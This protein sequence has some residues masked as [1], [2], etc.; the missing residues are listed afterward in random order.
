M[1]MLPAIT[2]TA[3]AYSTGDTYPQEYKNLDYYW[4]FN[5][6]P[7][8]GT[9]DDWN[10]CIRQCTS[11][12]AWC[13]NDRNGIP[14]TNQYKGLK[15]WG[16]GGQWGDSA[17]KAGMTVDMNPSV[18]SVAYWDHGTWGHVAWVSAVNGSTVTIEEYNYWWSDGPDQ[19]GVPGIWNWDTLPVRR[20][21]WSDPP[22]G[23]IHFPM[24][25]SVTPS[26]PTAPVQN[27]GSDFYAYI[28]NPNSGLFLEN[29]NSNVQ[30]ATPNGY[31]PRQIW[32][33]QLQ[34]D[35]QY[36]ITSMYDGRCIDASNWGTAEGTNIQVCV[37]SGNGAQRW[38]FCNEGNGGPYYVYPSY[39]SNQNRVW[40]VVGGSLVSGAN[41]QLWTNHYQT[42]GDFNGEYTAAQRFQVHQVPYVENRL[43]YDLGE[44]FYARIG[45]KGSYLE[46]TGKATESAR[47]MDVQTSKTLKSS[48]PKQIWH[49]TRLSDG[50]YKI[51]NE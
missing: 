49:F 22:T 24:N 44:N 2:P 29:R 28:S 15:Q 47:N 12:V 14:F 9:V 42:H 50:S 23:Y 13:L 25:G 5:N 17:R 11:F 26:Q 43:A 34:S 32:H 8:P 7:A 35:N 18:G 33:F 37:D 46:T 40:D 4:C 45:Y 10:F 39:I 21:G 36:K 38:L 41:I 48:D 3:E 30:L 51:V 20:G 1:G 6:F 19:Y 27:L 16:H 31:D